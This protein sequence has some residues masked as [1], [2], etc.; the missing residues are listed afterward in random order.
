MKMCRRLKVKIL[1]RESGVSSE[2]GLIDGHMGGRAT[3]YVAERPSAEAT[4]SERA[5]QPGD[6]ELFSWRAVVLQAAWFVEFP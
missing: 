5:D 3:Q 6:P 4:T 2:Y 1:P